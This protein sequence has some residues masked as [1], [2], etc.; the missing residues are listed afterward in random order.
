MLVYGKGL[1]KSQEAALD[2][3]SSSLAQH[4]YEN[5][6]GLTPRRLR[7]FG[8]LKHFLVLVA[9]VSRLNGYL[10]PSQ[11]T[12]DQTATF[13]HPQRMHTAKTARLS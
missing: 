13:C 2:V 5:L 8:L 9:Q 7:Q 1:F 3:A 4:E 11:T 12:V 6:A 10:Y